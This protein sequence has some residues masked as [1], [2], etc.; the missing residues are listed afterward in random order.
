MRRRRWTWLAAVVALGQV[1]VGLAGCGDSEDGA[2]AG[3][4]CVAPAPPAEAARK[5]G[6]SDGV[7]LLPGGRAV[8]PAGTET[9]LG[10]FPA[11]VVVHPSLKVAYVANTGYDKRAL[12]VVSLSDGKILQDLERPEVFSGLVVTPDGKRLFSSEGYAHLLE[13]YDIGSDGTLTPAA[14]LDVGKYPAGLALSQDGSTLWVGLFLG[15]ALV[16]V[17]VATLTITNTFKLPTRAY[18]LLDVPEKQEIYVT[19]FGD[20]FLMVV[21]PTTGEVKKKLEVGGNPSSLA[22]AAD[23][24]EVFVSVS[25]ADA[26]ITVDTTSHEVVDT[27][28]VGE[29]SLAAADGTPLPAS[30]P[31]SLALKGD[32]LYVIRAADNAVSVL[33]AATLEPKGAIPVGWYPTAVAISGDT[34]VVTNGKG[35]GTGPLAKGQSGKKSMKGS[36][37]LVSLSD[38]NLPESTATVEANVRRPSEV[39]PFECDGTFPIPTTTGGKTP[40]K[41]IVLLVRENKTYDALFGSLEN[42]D[43]DPSLTLYGEDIT[44]NISALARRFA[45]HD[46]FYDDSESSVQGHLWL[47]S[48]FVNDYMERT[49][50]EGY[51]DALADFGADSPT[52]RGQPD[53][54]TFF[55]HM[56][57]ND[58]SF[59][60]FGEVVGTFDEYDGVSV[61]DHT[62]LSFPGLFFN[63]SVKDEEKAKYVIDRLVTQEDF[64]QFVYLLLPNDH[65]QGSDAGAP[66]P[67]SM[68]SDNDY[69]TGLVVE[70]I[71]HSKFWKETAIFIVEDDPQSGAD[72]VDYHRSILVVAS[73][74]AKSG[75]VSHVQASYPSLFRSFE[76]ML[77]LPPM[78]RYDA[79][80]TPLYDAF[81]MKPNMAPYTALERTVP[82]AYNTKSSTGARWSA[83][84]DFDGPDRAPDLGDLLWWMKRGAPPAGS[85]LAEELE[86]GRTPKAVEDDDDDDASERDI[87]DRGWAHAKRWL[88]AHPEVK[89]DIRPQPSQ[90]RKRD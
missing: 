15:K 49:W 37:S 72:H 83:M 44:P 88:A 70:A 21:D 29:P 22:K 55:T 69:A 23:G 73:P 47:T 65:T 89:A 5:V 75:H 62:D 58:I 71:S 24:S 10:G 36:L 79:M 51:R 26:V 68:I 31:T 27:Q 60:N 11:N 4:A 81:T 42:G 14:Q 56:M 50:I 54:G 48:S 16:Q 74:W 45:H 77:G 87:Y 28:A 59:L 67:E 78:N 34:L 12:Q 57:K 43:G 61:L 40:I 86:E 90:R 32:D 7:T 39:Y 52:E 66:T 35:V 82:D 6:T 17:D 76:L 80:A 30:S 8:S 25:D 33:D 20:R 85:R 63:L 84:M 13:A 1:A 2:P 9:V 18:A 38:V 46:N 64:P 19:G 3:K 53:F 41:H